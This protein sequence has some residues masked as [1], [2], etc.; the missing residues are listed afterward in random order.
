M[1]TTLNRRDFVGTSVRT[2]TSLALAA[3]PFGASALLAGSPSNRVVVALMGAGGRGMD[4]IRKMVQVPDVQVKYVCDVEDARGK[5]AVAELAKLQGAAPQHVVDLRTVLDDKEVQGVVVA[6]PEQW[7]ALATIWACQAGKDVYVEKNISLSVWEGRKMIE[8]ARKHQ[9]VVQAGF[10]N[11]SAPYAVSARDYIAGGGLGK[12]L[13]VNVYGMLSGV[14]GSYPRPVTPDSDPPA[15][16]DWD[17]WLGPAR[18]RRYNRDVHRGWYGYWDY[19]G[20]NASDAIHT[21]DL[22]RLVLGDPLH[23]EAVT[24]LGGRCQFDDRG[25]M[26]D[27]QIVAYQYPKMVVSFL[28][29]G[30]TPYL[31]KSP[32]EV[33]YGKKWPYWPQNADRIE[34]FGTRRMMY[35]GRHGAGWQVFE[36]ENKL[37][38]ED[39]GY[40]PDKW[41]IPNF[42]DCIRSRKRPN[43]DIEQGHYSACLEHFANVAYRSGSRHL[44]FDQKSETFLDNRAANRLLK[45]AYRG[46]YRVPDEV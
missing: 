46:P 37:V 2:G 29:T 14:V 4:V 27:V 30:F 32:A 26:P 43:G 28:N 42:I 15:G 17:R 21:L 5:S 39:K 22:M 6:T 10:Q 24:C 40:H 25:E 31:A 38:A 44:T 18:L 13:Y 34:I 7:H 12:V 16:L 41:H 20:G 1:A 3:V 9:R 8:A 11:R 33:R 19:S 36:G 35:L 23:P 45:P